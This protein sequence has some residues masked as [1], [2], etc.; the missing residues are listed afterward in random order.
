M[1][2][3]DIVFLVCL[4]TLIKYIFDLNFPTTMV[5]FM[6]FCY[7]FLTIKDGNNTVNVDSVST[8]DDSASDDMR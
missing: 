2:L 1:D 3:S 5:I 6:I 8:A 4:V 7:D